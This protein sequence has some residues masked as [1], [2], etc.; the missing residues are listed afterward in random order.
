MRHESEEFASAA[1][2]RLIGGG[3]TLPEP[4]GIGEVGTGGGEWSYGAER[5]LYGCLWAAAIS[6]QEELFRDGPEES[7][8][9]GRLVG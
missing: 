5:T 9:M 6:A 7:Q 4:G 2:T 8:M 3:R 1:A